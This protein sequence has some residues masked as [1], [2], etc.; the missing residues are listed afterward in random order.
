MEDI[1]IK[2]VNNPHAKHAITIILWD[3]ISLIE[4]KKIIH[5]KKKVGRNGLLP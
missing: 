1:I 4:N 2:F 5:L 3:F